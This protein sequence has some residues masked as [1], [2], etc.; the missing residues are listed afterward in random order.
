MGTIIKPYG[1]EGSKHEQ[2]ERMFD[3]IAPAYDRMNHLMSFGSDRAWRRKTIKALKKH[4]QGRILDI[5]C[6][7]GDMTF[8]IH[9]E[10]SP[11]ELVGADLSEGMLEV[12]RRKWKQIREG[13][14]R[15][16]PVK[17]GLPGKKGRQNATANPSDNPYT[18]APDFIKC[19][20]CEG[21][22]F[23]DRSFDAVTVAFGVRNFEDL[24]K[25]ISEIYRVL[26]HGGTLAVLEL[27]VPAG[28]PFKQFYNLYAGRIIP[29][30]G[31]KISKDRKAYSYLPESIAAF[32]QREHFLSI[33]KRCGFTE[34]SYKSLTF[35]T[36][37]LY[38]AVRE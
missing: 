2:V 32:P 13:Q 22:P 33:L 3:N 15:K 11:K 17:R 25:G 21:L 28:F 36:C 35:G 26:D 23:N 19:D 12:A 8:E 4:S 34:C 27:S 37:T 1:D 6:G 10:L 20:C 30:I 24:E 5:A 38:L 9:R 14:E 29:A 7:T 16:E 31:G 18:P